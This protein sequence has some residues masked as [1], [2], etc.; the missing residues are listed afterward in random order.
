MFTFIIEENTKFGLRIL[1]VSR[2]V[3]F[4]R[5]IFFKISFFKDF[6]LRMINI[7]NLC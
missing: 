7:N 5:K 4:F 2:K 6:L 3:I 1:L